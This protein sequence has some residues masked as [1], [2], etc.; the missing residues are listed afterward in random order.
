MVCIERQCKKYDFILI[1]F[2]CLFKYWS[3]YKLKWNE[4]EYG[5]LRE[6]RLPHDRIWK[7]VS[8]FFKPK[9]RFIIVRL[10]LKLRMLYCTIT[11][12]ASHLSVKSQRI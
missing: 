6:I 2:F 4:S 9:I 5:G 8:T 12:M 3:D 11:P 1:S 10:Y 7:P